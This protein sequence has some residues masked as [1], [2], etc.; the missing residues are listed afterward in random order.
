[1]SSA[2]YRDYMY[3][4]A[5][6]QSPEGAKAALP[7]EGGAG[8]SGSPEPAPPHRRGRQD[9]RNGGTPSEMKMQYLMECRRR[10][11]RPAP[12]PVH[13]GDAGDATPTVSHRRHALVHF[14][15]FGAL[16]AIGAIMAM[17]TGPF[18]LN[19]AVGAAIAALFGA[20]TFKKIR[21]WRSTALSRK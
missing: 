12:R 8:A 13:A 10:A 11:S 2:I 1:M 7:A 16:C 3:W 5:D 15:G 14:G 6:G 21:M 19:I 9:V 20:D 18:P 4:D 17:Q